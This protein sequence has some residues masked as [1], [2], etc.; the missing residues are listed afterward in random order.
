MLAPDAVKLVDPK[1]QMVAEGGAI[2]IIG[3]V[4]VVT[5]TVALFTQPFTFVPTTV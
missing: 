5:A 1:A 4:F 2:A 3:N